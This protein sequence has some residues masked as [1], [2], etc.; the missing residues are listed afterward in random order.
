MGDQRNRR[1]HACHCCGGSG[2]MRRGMICTLCKGT[3][4]CGSCHQTLTLPN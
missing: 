1:P 3:G 4:Q 2:E